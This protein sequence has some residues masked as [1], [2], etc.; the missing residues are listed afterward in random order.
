[1]RVQRCK[2]LPGASKPTKIKN[3]PKEKPTSK[4]VRPARAQIPST[5]SQPAPKGDPAL[6]GKIASL[7]K[8]ERKKVKASDADRVARRLA[9]KKAKVLTDKGVKSLE[10]KKDR[11]RV[12]RPKK[13]MNTGVK[14]GKKRVRSGKAVAKLN[15][16]K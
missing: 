9:K 16:K 6:G 10:G 14:P 5:Q 15:T 2:T 12:R 13:D 8:E 4:G 7:S 3:I 1:M 11:E